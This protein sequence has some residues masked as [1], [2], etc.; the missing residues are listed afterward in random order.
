M[1]SA[2]CI[3]CEMVM[4]YLLLYYTL[5]CIGI[6]DRVLLLL[7]KCVDTSH[8]STNAVSLDCAHTKKYYLINHWNTLWAGIDTDNGC[9]E[10]SVA[11][12]SNEYTYR[13]CSYHQLHPVCVCICTKCQNRVNTL[14]KNENWWKRGHKNRQREVRCENGIHVSVNCCWYT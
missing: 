13:M 8:I 3:Y 1:A 12:N 10:H 14:K 9:S 2:R 7:L 4:T 5:H 6:N 11:F